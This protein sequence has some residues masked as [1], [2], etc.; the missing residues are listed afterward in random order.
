MRAFSPT[1]LIITAGD[2][3]AL[4]LTIFCPYT[5]SSN[6]YGSAFRTMLMPN[7]HAA[8]VTGLAL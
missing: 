5:E 7:A 3:N 4:G 8:A 1:W 6:A 2:V